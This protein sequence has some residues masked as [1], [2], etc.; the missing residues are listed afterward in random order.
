MPHRKVHPHPARIGRTLLRRMGDDFTFLELARAPSLLLSHSIIL[1]ETI[2]S[3][4]AMR[5]CYQ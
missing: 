1:L 2:G 3:N 4:D 5:H